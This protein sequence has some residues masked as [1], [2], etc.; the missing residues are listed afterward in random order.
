MNVQ[1]SRREKST[2][3]KLY[4]QI[5]ACNKLSEQKKLAHNKFHEQNPARNKF[6]EE[7]QLTRRKICFSLN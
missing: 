2:W 4:E 6:H 3:N 1:V 5:S 7:Y